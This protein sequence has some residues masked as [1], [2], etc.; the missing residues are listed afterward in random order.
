MLRR[1]RRPAACKDN[2]GTTAIEFAI[3]LPVLLTFVMGILEVG[4][5]FFATMTIESAISNTARLGKTG[6]SASGIAREQTIINML[7]NRTAGLI[8]MDNVTISYLSYPSF[9]TIGDVEPFH[10]TNSN[11]TRDSGETYDDINGNGE[12]DTDM[13]TEGLG[14]ANDVVVYTVSYPWPIMT[15]FM[16]HALGTGGYYTISARTVV[17]NEPYNADD[18]TIGGMEE[19]E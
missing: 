12:W 17:K 4:M 11:D 16:S 14:D 6:F 1:S 19:E 7:E 15:P 18:L 5:I 10:D 8:D 9:D 13:G 2:A 3:I